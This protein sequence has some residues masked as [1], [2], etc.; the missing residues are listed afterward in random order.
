MFSVIIP[1]KN[2]PELL[3]RCLE[4]IPRMDDIQIIVV[5]DNS[6]EKIVDFVT[7][8]GLKDDHVEIY[9]TKEGKGAGYARNTGVKYAKGKWLV[10]ADADDFFTENAFNHLFSH[11][12]SSED[13]IYFKSASFYSDTNEPARRERK[14][15][16]FIDDYFEGKM[17]SED[18]LRYLWSV[19]WAKMIKKELI[20]RQNILFDET[21]IADDLF[22]SCLAGHYASSINAV[23]TVIYMIAVKRGSLSNVHNLR[24]YKVMF[25]VFNK[26]NEFLR[27]IGKKYLK[28]SLLKRFFQKYFGDERIKIKEYST[29]KYIGT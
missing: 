25:A 19:P 23:D 15:N 28:Q 17:H 27:K 7:I 10:F 14:Y 5:D 18:R 21:P 16:K 22:F 1:H 2:T 26:R 24:M 12:N 11:A 29:T 13:I 3:K 6:N 4:S 9:L 8:A 20:N